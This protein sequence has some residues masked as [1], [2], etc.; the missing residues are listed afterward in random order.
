MTGVGSMLLLITY[1]TAILML[2]SA[3]L[4]VVIESALVTTSSEAAR[5]MINVMAAVFFLW[6]QLTG[7][8]LSLS[9]EFRD[10][11]LMLI[12]FFTLAI[13]LDKRKFSELFL[14]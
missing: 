10:I 2:K 14:I 6:R 8:C 11:N 3:G 4:G 5:A 12:R 13:I 1:G 7:P 9:A